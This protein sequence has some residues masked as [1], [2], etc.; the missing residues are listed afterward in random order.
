MEKK[1][2]LS[3][4]ELFLVQDILNNDNSRLF[5]KEHLYKKPK[6]DPTFE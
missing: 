1:Y 2:F 5:I 4:L 6:C 3:N